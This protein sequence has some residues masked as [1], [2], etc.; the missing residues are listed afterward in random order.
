MGPCR[1]ISLWESAGL[2]CFN[3]FMTSGKKPKIPVADSGKTL[4]AS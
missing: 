1:I 2:R 3:S 4:R